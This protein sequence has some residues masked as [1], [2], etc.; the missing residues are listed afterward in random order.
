[1]PT[2]QPYGG[3]EWY[4]SCLSPPSAL[5]LFANVL[6]KVEAGGQGLQWDS[7][8]MSVT[9]ESSFPFSAKVVMIALIV[10]IIVFAVL[11]AYLDRVSPPLPPHIIGDVPVNGCFSTP[12]PAM[13]TASQ[14][15][16]L[17]QFRQLRCARR[18][19]GEGDWPL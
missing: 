9:S 12:A 11:A 17:S 19:W 3:W 16:S 10:D 7:L 14:E 15:T 6:I 13:T 18:G 1:M 8:A 5:S 4:L 2:F